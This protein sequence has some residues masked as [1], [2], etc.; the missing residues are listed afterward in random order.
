MPRVSVVIPAHNAAA[1]LERALR[2]IETQTFNDYEI[3]L[4]DDGS[5]DGTAEIAQSVEGL[6]YLHQS[7]RGQAVARNQGLIEADGDLIAF[8]D[9]DD[10]WLP[11][12]LERQVTFMDERQMRISYTDTYFLAGGKR[13]R[14]SK[15]AHV[16]K[17]QILVP[18]LEQWLENSFITINT[19]IAE[20]RLLDEVGGFDEDAP[21]V[22]NEDYGLWLRVALSGTS[23]G[24]LDVP[25]AVYYRGH[26]S[27]S[28]DS[29]AMLERY[30]QALS[31]FSARYPF[32]SEAQARLQR[33]LERTQVALGA[34]LL[35]H[36]RVRE[37]LPLL[38]R[39]NPGDLTRKAGLFAKRR[40][41]ALLLRHE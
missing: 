12:K 9:A 41:R 4:V 24:Y 22:S 14:Y 26:S 34:K 1:F 10:E 7:N 19:V 37:A 30:S 17:G 32:S 2:S 21:F 25:L 40:L 29:I 36:G 15:I 23:F 20:K 27:H 8:L 16:Y 5:T 13:I 6:R 35:K 18:L 11:E 33:T 3:I 31:Y 39:G 28:S 38:K